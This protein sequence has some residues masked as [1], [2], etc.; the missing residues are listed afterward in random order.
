[1]SNIGPVELL[2]LLV[3]AVGFGWATGA[4]A[5][6][7]GYGFWPFAIVGGL[8]APIPLLVTAVLP[9]RGRGRDEL[10]PGAPTFRT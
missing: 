2:I 5:R 1:M 3:I 6:S 7:K 8:L 9:R 10:Q 4:L